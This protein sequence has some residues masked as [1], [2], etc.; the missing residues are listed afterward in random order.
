VAGPAA[1]SQQWADAAFEVVEWFIG[2]Q[3]RT[4]GHE[5]SKECQAQQKFVH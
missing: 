2:G 1:S 4:A 3:Q 5:L